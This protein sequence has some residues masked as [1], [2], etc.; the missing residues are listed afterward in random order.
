MVHEMKRIIF[1]IV[2][3]CAVCSCAVQKATTDEEFVSEIQKDMPFKASKLA[4]VS[5]CDNTYYFA[6]DTYID[7]LPDYEVDANGVLWGYRTTFAPTH[8]TQP[9]NVIWRNIVINHK[10]KRVLCI[11]R[12]LRDGK[13]FGYV[14]V[15]QSETKKYNHYG[16][17]HYDVSDHRALL[18]VA[19][20]IM[21]MSELSVTTLN[22]II[23]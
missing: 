4:A 18:N 14:Y 3:T 15:L 8:S 11:D 10:A 16:T 13:T 21:G 7:L 17:F 23:K 5:N 12:L 20:A 1:L 22:T 2:I 6:A 9:A 19:D